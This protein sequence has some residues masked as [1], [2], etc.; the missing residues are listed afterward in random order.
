MTD[1]TPTPAERFTV[2]PWTVGWQTR[3]PFGLRAGRT[4]FEDVDV[5]QAAAA[6]F[7]ST[8]LDQSAVEH[9]LGAR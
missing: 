4:A 2:G 9:L 3:D 7:S 8:Q 5:E 6:G 1:L